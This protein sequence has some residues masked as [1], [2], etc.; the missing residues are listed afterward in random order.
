M[1]KP[2]YLRNIAT[3]LKRSNQSARCPATESYSV[4]LGVEAPHPGGL[5]ATYLN[6][7]GY[8]NSTLRS[9]HGLSPLENPTSLCC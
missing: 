5:M 1:T 8:K 2:V 7:I 6:Y 9:E 4:H 3:K